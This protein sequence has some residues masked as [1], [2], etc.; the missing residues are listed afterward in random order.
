MRRKSGDG[1]LNN[2]YLIV[3]CCKYWW[4]NWHRSSTIV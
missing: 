1:S 2:L 3:P 4:W